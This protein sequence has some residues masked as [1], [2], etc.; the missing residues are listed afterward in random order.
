MRRITL[1]ISLIFIFTHLY[2]QQNAITTSPQKIW[3]DSVFSSLSLDAKIGQ[4]IMIRAHSN[5]TK[6]YHDKIANIVKEYQVGG[7]CFFQGGPV[8]QAQLTN[9]YQSLSKTPML[10]ALDAE[11]GLGMRLDSTFSFPQQMTLGATD[12]NSVI[13]DMGTEIARQCRRIGI[14]LNFAPVVDINSN[15]NNPVINS[16][17][18]GENKY[19]VADKGLM[20]MYGLQ[21]HGVIAT[22]KHFPGHGD[23]D[24]D[25]HL[26]LPIINHDVQRLHSTE[27]YPFTKLISNGLQGIMTAHLYIPS[28][29]STPNTA[30]TI[31]WPVVTGLLKNKLNFKGLVITDALEMKG[32]TKY[33]KPGILEV[34]ALIAGNDILLLPTDVKK[35]ING[36]KKAVTDSILSISSIDE[37]VIK[38]LN[39]KYIV[40][41]NNYKPIN[42]KNIYNELHTPYE[43]Y[44]NRQI[45]EN[46]ITLVKN[47]EDFLPLKKPDTLQ[48]ASVALGTNRK[49]HFQETLDFYSDIKDFHLPKNI[50]NKKQLQLLQDISGY[51]TVIISLH[52]TSNYPH[53]NFGITD[54]EV[55]IVKAIAQKHKVILN[56]LAIPYALSKFD[57]IPNITSILVSYEDRYDN[58]EVSGQIIFGGLPA[59]GHLPVSINK[60]YPVNHSITTKKTRLSFSTFEQAGVKKKYIKLIDSITNNGIDE[61]AFPGCQIFIAHKGN[62]FFNKN[63]GFHTYNNKTKVQSSDIYDLASITKIAATTTSIM[64]MYEDKKFNID[65]RI[66][67]YLPYL[68]NSNKKEIIIRELMAH[69]A[70]LQAWIPYYRKTILNKELNHDIYNNTITEKYSI[71]VAENLY[72]NKNYYHAIFDTIAASKLRVSKKYK[73]SDLGFYLLYKAIENVINEPLEIYTKMHFYEPLGLKT[74]GFKPRNRFALERIIPTE[75]D[76]IF[77]HQLIQGDVHD[78]GAAMLGGVSGH[79][80]LFSNATDLGVMMQMFLNGGFYGGEF[81]LKPNTIEQFTKEQF[82]INKNRRG[83]GFDRPLPP[84]QKNGPTCTKISQRS[85]GHSGF[86]GTYA[87]ADPANKSVYI[88]L[89]NRIYPDASNRKLISMDIRTNIQEII[90]NALENRESYAF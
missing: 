84:G 55:N 70:Q 7:L 40:G 6:Q 36:I 85:F 64:K 41:L 79:A 42:T 53:R 88:F 25:S 33:N 30:S 81:Y 67:Y 89:S 11:W 1:V 58:Q 65:Q 29:D 87:W 62:V 9:R 80:G 78:P 72:I 48:I 47:R 49:E 28:L 10:I 26:T 15:R 27:L 4:L 17:S 66:S 24:S 2:S 51:N 39:H 31:S 5:K 54:D 12:N 44:L 75:K 34:K 45:T 73:Y 59:K 74:M 46:A 83:I 86:T 13:Y 57:S 43:K 50:T 63:Y 56:L 19:D 3:V 18:F 20:Y 90:Y 61:K 82:P 60:E 35:A 14:N 22:A 52:N 38:I 21:E 68:R 76:D 69:Q 77:R 71:R 8:R 37:K 16:R 23:T 32:V